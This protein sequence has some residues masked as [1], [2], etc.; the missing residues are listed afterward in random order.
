[1][2]MDATAGNPRKLLGRALVSVS[3]LTGAL[4]VGPSLIVNVTLP[5]RNGNGASPIS[6]GSAGLPGTPP[7]GGTSVTSA[8][9]VTVWP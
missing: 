1:M 4:R 9:N 2:L 8:V 3:T 5:L 6:L 7:A